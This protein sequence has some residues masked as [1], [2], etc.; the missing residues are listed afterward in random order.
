VQ[1]ND[2]GGGGV[3]VMFDRPGDI[4]RSFGPMARQLGSVRVPGGEASRPVTL[5]QQ[6]TPDGKATI[7]V[8]P[9]WR[10][11][12]WGNGAV[13]VAGPQGQL[14]DVGIFLP[15][16]VQPTFVGP[17]AGAIY[18]PFIAD[19]AIAVR[20]VSEAQ[21]RQAAARGAPA[22][23][24]TTTSPWSTP[25]RSTPVRGPTTTPRWA[26]RTASSSATSP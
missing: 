6:T 11:I 9:G 18:L 3:A 16:M 17:V 4:G 21:S 20:A 14:V 2:G 25:R 10:I 5:Q 7:G 22:G 12:G 8:P 26:H 1:L 19:P 13:D 23:G 15:I 24:R